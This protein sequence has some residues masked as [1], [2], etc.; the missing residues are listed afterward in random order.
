MPTPLIIGHVGGR[1]VYRIAGGDGTGTP[2]LE[3]LRERRTQAREAADVI[4]TRAAEESRDLAA[5]ELTAYQAQVVATREADDAIEVEHER[6]L[7]EA[8]AA[9]RAGRGP[10]LNRQALDTARAFRSA[11]FAKNPAPIEVYSDLPDE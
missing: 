4:L 9:S 2:L 11:I 5:D 7:A 10:T 8:R 6:L 3:Q 1:P